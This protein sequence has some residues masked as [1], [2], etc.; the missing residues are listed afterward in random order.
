MTENKLYKLFN[1]K[2]I[3][4]DLII[5]ILEYSVERM[6]ND[7]LYIISKAAILNEYSNVNKRWYK[8]DT[9]T[10]GSDFSIPYTFVV[11]E[12]CSEPE[13]SINILSKCDCCIRHNTNKPESLSWE[14]MWAGTFTRDGVKHY[15]CA[16]CTCPCRHYSRWIIRTFW[17]D[18]L[19]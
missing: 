7:M 2:N 4:D 5:S 17:P 11:S 1:K 10:I 3:P 15:S 12:C 9:H 19:Y 8:E 14:K 6:S 16:T 13:H 18:G